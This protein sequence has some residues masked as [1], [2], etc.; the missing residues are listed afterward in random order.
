MIDDAITTINYRNFVNAI[1]YIFADAEKNIFII[2]Q[3]KTEPM[4]DPT[5]DCEGSGLSIGNVM[6]K[7]GKNLVNQVSA[8]I[9]ADVFKF[10]SGMEPKDIKTER[11]NLILLH[12]QLN[13]NPRHANFSRMRNSVYETDHFKNMIYITSNWASGT[14]L[15]KLTDCTTSM[16]KNPW[17]SIYIKDTDKQWFEKEYEIR[18]ANDKMGL[19]FGYHFKNK[20]KIWYCYSDELMQKVYIK[21]PANSVD[22]VLL[23]KYE[24]NMKR[25]YC[26]SLNKW[27]VQETY[28][29]TDNL[30]DIIEIQKNEDCY[31]Y[32]LN[33]SKQNRDIFF[34]IVSG[35]LSEK[36]QL[37]TDDLEIPL[38]LGSYIDEE[39]EILRQKNAKKFMWLTS[40]LRDKKLPN[41]FEVLNE[42]HKYSIED[43]IF[44]L[45]SL[46]GSHEIVAIISFVDDENTARQSSKEFLKRLNKFRPNLQGESDEDFDEFKLATNKFNKNKKICVFYQ[47][48]RMNLSS[49]PKINEG[50]RDSDRIRN[51][52]SIL[53]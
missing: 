4:R 40:V 25:L 14:E 3:I 52:E 9:C 53:R 24:I 8:I 29:N 6:Y 20:L 42:N 39:C 44:N 41:G 32:P 23:P 15:V 35:H 11:E 19:G 26:R 34:G 13:H 7:I 18:V 38:G 48:N 43:S 33:E 45:V 51:E 21:K 37:Y 10:N 27:I 46:D 5:L 17:S 36:E 22:C 28:S 47:D 30:S 31:C 1:F 12:P 2:P 50:I 16:I 49:Y